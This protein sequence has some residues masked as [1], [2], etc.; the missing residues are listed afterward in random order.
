V[1][2][3][4]QL[5]D[6]FRRRKKGEQEKEELDI[7]KRSVDTIALIRGE[8]L[9]FSGVTRRLEFLKKYGR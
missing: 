8:L 3:T 4:R 7:C 9:V 6:L 5:V 2:L 1:H